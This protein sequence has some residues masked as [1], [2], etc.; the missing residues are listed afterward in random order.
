MD[1]EERKLMGTRIRQCRKEA[2]FSQDELAERLDMK[3]SNI[4]GYEA[5]RV[6]P[7]GNIIKQL[8]DIFSISTDFLLG[9]TNDPHGYAA[10]EETTSTRTLDTDVTPQFS[11]KE[12]HD[13]ATALE[14]L[15]SNLES[16]KA[17]AFD[18]EPMT[19]DDKELL[20]DALEHSLRTARQVAKRKFTPKKFKK[21]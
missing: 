10:Q 11:P 5:G 16:K 4:A 15:M 6:I 21:D 14:Q 9:G 3:R 13:I 17:L 8:A 1:M 19:I 2:G 20:R 7:P 18:G 12:E